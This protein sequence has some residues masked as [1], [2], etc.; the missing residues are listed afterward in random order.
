LLFFSS[1]R[2]RRGIASG[3]T[4]LHIIAK[5]LNRSPLLAPKVK[6]TLRASDGT[7][8]EPDGTGSGTLGH[9]WTG[10]TGSGSQIKLTEPVPHEFNRFG[11]NFAPKDYFVIEYFLVCCSDSFSGLLF[12]D[13]IMDLLSFPA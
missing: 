1:V 6:L 2:H 4:P 9:F 5:H 12:R 10:G 11:C 13:Y 7:D 3:A 8:P